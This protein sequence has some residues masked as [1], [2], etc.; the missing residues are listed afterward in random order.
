MHIIQ[1]LV[2][3]LV[4]GA[5]GASYMSNIILVVILVGHS[6]AIGIIKPYSLKSENIRCIVNMMLILLLSLLSTVVGLTNPDKTG[7]GF[8]T[9]SPYLILLV[10]LISISFSSV[11]IYRQ[12]KRMILIYLDSRENKNVA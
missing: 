8:R 9:I 5:L 2:L 3:G 7:V 12:I 4:F 10:T 11:F 6:I 1:R